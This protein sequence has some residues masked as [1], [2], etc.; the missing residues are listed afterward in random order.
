[1]VSSQMGTLA[2]QS[3]AYQAMVSKAASLEA[4]EASVVF[5]ADDPQQAVMGPAYSVSKVSRLSFVM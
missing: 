5:L 1:M 3:P 2:G 4:L